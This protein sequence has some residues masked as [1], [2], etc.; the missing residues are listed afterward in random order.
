M[1]NDAQ[2]SVNDELCTNLTY[3]PVF[4]VYIKVKH[5]FSHKMGF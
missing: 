2:K 3:S 4:P 5:C 1:M